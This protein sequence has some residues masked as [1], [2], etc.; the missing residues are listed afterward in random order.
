MS[1]S[2]FIKM[3]GIVALGKVTVFRDSIFVKHYT[4]IFNF[5]FS[6]WVVLNFGCQKKECVT[7]LCSDK[8]Y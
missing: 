3:K 5:M 7:L 1:F 8:I 4:T 6:I 2:K